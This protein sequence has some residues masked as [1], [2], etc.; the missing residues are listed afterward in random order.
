M[1]IPSY[2]ERVHPSRRRLSPRHWGH[3]APY[4]AGVSVLMLSV[5]A[6]GGDPGDDGS[7]DSNDADTA[8]R[9]PMLDTA[10]PVNTPNPGASSSTNEGNPSLGGLEPQGQNSRPAP[11]TPTP[12][13]PPPSGSET[14]PPVVAEPTPPSG[15]LDPV[16]PAPNGTC[17]EFRSGTQTIMGLSTE[18][19]AGDPVATKGPLLF[20]WHGTGGSGR[21]ALLQLPQSVQR[22]I[23]AKGGI[24]IAP[25]D[26]GQVRA[27]VDVTFVLGVWYDG[28]DLDFA[29]Q[30]VACA[31]QN[32]NVDPRQIY[33]TGCSAGGLMAGVMSLERSSYVAAAA[34]NSGGIA[35]PVAVEDRTRIPAV[36]TMHGGAGDNV[37]V[38]FGDTSRQ[39]IST[40]SPLGAFMVDCN[41]NSGHCG[42]PASLHEKAW[43]FMKAHPFGTAPSPYESGLPGDFPNFCAIQ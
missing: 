37:I 18:I 33:V 30:I 3:L 25:S 23:V 7:D 19:V 38:N 26:N 43:E 24:V 13:T 35:L 36:M 20:T 6:C 14:T 12:T 5:A 10:G 9:A 11:V 42:A 34:P 22:D 15:D 4:M 21:Q 27:G 31:V 32:H 39:L 40:L 28:A 17:P 1:K 16:I 29:D 41:H 8:G 2:S